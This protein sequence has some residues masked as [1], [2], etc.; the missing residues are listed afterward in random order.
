MVKRKHKSTWR[1]GL[2]ESVA[3]D[4]DKKKIYYEYEPSD[5]KIVYKVPAKESTYTP[6]FYVTTKSG[7]TLIIESKGIWDYDDRFKLL[8]IKQQY[9]DLDIRFVFQRSK[10]KIR[11]GSKTTYA[12]ICRGDGRGPFKGIT[13]PYADKNIPREWLEE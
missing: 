13:W 12:D 9:P 7:K 8:L 6:D 2:E 5:G 4:L 11:K 1:S 10:S 3:K